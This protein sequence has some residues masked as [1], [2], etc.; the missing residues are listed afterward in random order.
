VDADHAFAKFWEPKGYPEYCS[1]PWDF[2][3]VDTCVTVDTDDIGAFLPSSA[4]PGLSDDTRSV[5]SHLKVVSS[6]RPY[7]LNRDR[8]DSSDFYSWE[9]HSNGANGPEHDRPEFDGGDRLSIETPGDASDYMGPWNETNFATMPGDLTWTTPENATGSSSSS[10]R[11][12]YDGANGYSRGILAFANTTNSSSATMCRFTDDGQIDIPARNLS[13]LG[14]GAGA[15]GI[16]YMDDGLAKGPDGLP[17]RLQ[18]FSG[19]TTS[20]TLQ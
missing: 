19:A 17:I 9:T 5:G 1:N 20:L 4:S 18:L 13:D 2:L 15:L 16:Y 6:G 7:K 11:I 8:I 3:A 12:R 10:L 14:A